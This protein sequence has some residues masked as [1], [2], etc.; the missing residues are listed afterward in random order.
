MT[1]RVVHAWQKQVSPVSVDL[2]NFGSSL[3]LKDDRHIA[4]MII[5]YLMTPIYYID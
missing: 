1:S 5:K 4:V 2:Y 3:L